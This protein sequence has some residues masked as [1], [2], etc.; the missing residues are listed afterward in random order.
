MTDVMGRLAAAR[1]ETLDPAPSPERRRRDLTAAL[2][3]AA[4]PR[5]RRSLHFSR[6]GACGVGLG[7]VAAG[8][9]TALV[10]TTGGHGTPESPATPGGEP[11][12]RL[13]GKEVLLAAAKAEQQPLGRFWFSNQVSSQSY[14]VRAKSGDYAIAGAVEE[15]YEWTSAKSGGGNLLYGRDL[16]ARP[17]T[18]ADE[19]AWRKAG[20]PKSFRVW[21][22]DHYATY[23]TGKLGRWDADYRQ[24]KP[25]GRFQIP[26]LSGQQGATVEELRALPTDPAKLAKIFFGQRL[27]LRSPAHDVI[28]VAYALREAPLPPKVRAG[29]MRALA[30]RP[31]IRE[32][33][34][35]T[36]ALGR[37]GV[38]LVGDWP[39]SGEVYHGY[40][41]IQAI[42]FSKQTGE[43]LAD[44]HVLTRSGG[45]YRT[46]KPGFVINALSLRGSGWVDKKPSP[47]AKPPFQ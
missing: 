18:K 4:E 46:A 30:M 20:K 19:V 17:L 2:N 13:G 16:P 42:I 29:L 10:V 31:G 33:A 35:M 1:P 6:R 15:T 24:A 32:V 5:A 22:N 40:G 45:I 3:Q 36:D 28:A 23:T 47:P 8:A 14:L 44:Q 25:G 12:Q 26:G 11:P 7:L 34:A 9:A 21:S 38:A 37:Q 27:G 41:A 39:E 43:V